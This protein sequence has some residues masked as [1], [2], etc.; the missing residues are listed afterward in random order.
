[1]VEVNSADGDHHT[2]VHTDNTIKFT[3]EQ[4]SDEQRQQLAEAVKGFEDECLLTFGMVSR[5]GKVIKKTDF[6]TPRR[7]TV[8]KD[9][10]KFQEMFDQAMHHALINQSKVM[11]NSVQNAIYEMMKSN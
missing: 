6:P 2:E 9:S 3:K 5:E 7:I 11:T 10:A 4:L 8:T 1:M